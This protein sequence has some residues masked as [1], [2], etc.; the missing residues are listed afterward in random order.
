MNKFTVRTSVPNKWSALYNNANNGGLSWCING[1]PTNPLNNV[2]ANC[3]G[4]ACG[5]FN[6]IYNQITGNKGIK[7]PQ[8]CCD[9]EQFWNRA[10]EIGLKRS[11]TKPQIGSIMV[12]E[13]IGSASGHVAVVEKINKNNTVILTSE[14]GWASSYFWNNYRYNDGNWGAGSNYRFLGF[15]YNPAVTMTIT[16]PKT[17][18]KKTKKKSNTTIAKEVIAGKWDV[19]PKRKQ[20]LE[21]AGYDYATIQKL[22]NKLLS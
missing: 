13:G 8:L 16:K 9:A 4:Y 7:Y 22:V 14:S 17:K 12:W 21:K 1:M 20:L 3:V 19:Y 2:L 6:E 5:R 11:K 10:K 18:K 15:I